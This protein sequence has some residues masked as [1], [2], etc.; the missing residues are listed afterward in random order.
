MIADLITSLKKEQ[1]DD[2]S[3]KLY[4]DKQIPK[5]ME[6]VVLAQEGLDDTIKAMTSL[7]G[8]M[9]TLA[10]EIKGGADRIKDLDEAVAE[11][12]E[13]RKEEHESYFKAS[14]EKVTTKQLIQTAKSMLKGFYEGGETSLLQP[15]AMMG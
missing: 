13:Q 9:E 8:P 3:K 14:S 1:D 5:T 4:C 15:A 2:D 12:S 6:E 11:A 10:G 7:D